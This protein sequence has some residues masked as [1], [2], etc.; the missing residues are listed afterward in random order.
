MLVEPAWQRRIHLPTIQYLHTRSCNLEF[1]NFIDMIIHLFYVAQASGANI[2]VK[3]HGH[4]Y[5][6]MRNRETL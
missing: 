6:H 4:I 2:R 5:V 1:P 3:A